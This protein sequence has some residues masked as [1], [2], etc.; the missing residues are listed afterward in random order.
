MSAS[1]DAALLAEMAAWEAAGL[2]RAPRDGAACAPGEFTSNDTLSLS[3]HPR[4]LAAARAAL[5]EHGAGG[6]ASRLLGG[7][8]P[9]D[10][11]AETAAADWLG[12][13]AALLFPS[14]FT[15]NL[16]LVSAL[17]GRGDAIVSDA[18]NH[19]SLID[20]ARLSRARVLVHPHGD[21]AATERMLASASGARRRLV[22]TE[23]VFSME[24][25]TAPLA[26]L[27]ELCARHD[28][29]LV[30]DEA[31]SAGLIGPQGAGAWSA[32]REAGLPPEH[33]ARLAARLL[34]GGK[35][36]GVAGG[37]VVGSRALREHLL[38]R[39]RSFVFTTAVP[40]AVSGAL[41]AAIGLARGADAERAHVHESARRVAHALGAPAP[42]AAIVSVHVGDGARALS[43]AGSLA[44]R[45]L[46]V[47]AVRPPTVP[48]GTE[49][50]RVVCHAHN[51]RAHVDALIA[52]LREALPA[53]PALHKP[54][55]P[56]G[57]DPRPAHVIA[58]VG[59]DT[60]IGKTVV[61]ALL[62]RAASRARSAAPVSY[63]KPVQTGTDSDSVE[64][65]R[66]LTGTDGAVRIEEPLHEYPLPASPD[67]AAADAGARIDVP[68]LGR[69]MEEFAAGLSGGLLFVEFAGGLLVPYDDA[70]TQADLLTAHRPELV[71]VARSGLGTL[72]HTL[73]TLEALAA[74]GLH[75]G[76]LVLVGPP[77]AEN[78][79]TLAR[80]SGIPAVFELPPLEP[81]DGAALDCWLDGQALDAWMATRLP[82]AHDSPPALSPIGTP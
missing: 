51:D 62:C 82:A 21:L 75:P 32:A 56:R 19:A 66:L 70:H 50:L 28:A 41:V 22:L 59:T 25:D 8:S 67:Q 1:L 34:T 79:A 74:R 43:L 3:R 4:V 48:A 11:A 29:W 69:R 13:E 71:L 6:R 15:G 24:G 57:P 9:L 20:A 44:R 72:N 78:R 14:G 40:P 53:V 12:A 77:H 55:R 37:F 38:N 46:D 2:R 49:R 64:V 26:G 42:A 23:G 5:E 52:T 10:A 63:W 30:V 54:G 80:R 60:G 36:L 76:A 33:E 31:H 39:A 35:A 27:A 68:A 18:A 16:G 61:S 65:A 45:G 17:V 7:G 81:L 58:V 73:L 47:R